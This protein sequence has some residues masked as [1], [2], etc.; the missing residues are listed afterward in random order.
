MKRR[1]TRPL[2]LASAGLAVLTVAG[3][4]LTSGN[5]M[6]CRPDAGECYEPEITQD[7]GT[8]GGSADAGDGGAADAGDGG[9]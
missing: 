5:L 7:G 8:D 1:L 3:G 2:L 9:I 4:C 6:A